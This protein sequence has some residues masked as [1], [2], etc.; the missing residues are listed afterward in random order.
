MWFFSVFIIIY[1]KLPFI[2]LFNVVLRKFQ[3]SPPSS[4]Y[5][6]LFISS[7]NYVYTIFRFL[8]PPRH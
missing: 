3:L 6:W 5:V 7:F 4:V 1:L 2:F 8:S